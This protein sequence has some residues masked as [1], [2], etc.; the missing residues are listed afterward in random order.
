MKTNPHTEACGQKQ[1]IRQPQNKNVTI[2]APVHKDPHA[3]GYHTSLKSSQRCWPD[4]TTQPS[5][6]ALLVLRPTTLSPVSTEALGATQALA[7]SSTGQFCSTDPGS[8]GYGL[9]MSPAYS[10]ECQGTRG[11]GR[12]HPCSVF[13]WGVTVKAKTNWSLPSPV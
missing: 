3:T 10:G 8:K 2:S 9:R 7:L 11:L 5:P 6:H 13:G 12:I 1:V 4:N